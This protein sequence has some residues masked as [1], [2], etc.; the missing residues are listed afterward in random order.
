M[1]QLTLNGQ[2]FDI[3]A[4]R[5]DIQPFL[6]ALENQTTAP[7]TLYVDAA[8][9]DANAGTATAPLLTMQGAFSR[10]PKRV[11]H[12]VNINVGPGTFAGAW[13]EGYTIDRSISQ[14]TAAG[15]QVNGTL[16]NAVAATGASSGTVA[17][18]TVAVFT[19]GATNTITKTAA[20][21]TVNDFRGK[22]L[23]FTSGARSG[24]YYPIMS[25]T[26]TVLTVGGSF[27]ADGGAP[28]NGDSFQIKDYAT[29]FDSSGFDHV[30]SATGY[31]DRYTGVYVW[32]VNNVGAGAEALVFKDVNFRT[33]AAYIDLYIGNSW[34]TLWRCK[35]SAVLNAVTVGG[36]S[37]IAS[38][39]STYV[40]DDSQQGFFA[41]NETLY[42]QQVA[43]QSSIMSV[44]DIA[45]SVGTK[46]GDW[47]FGSGY[48]LQVL[49]A[50]AKNIH[51]AF[52]VSVANI[53]MG[54]G[55]F[56]TLETGVS[57]SYGIGNASLSQVVIDAGYFASCAAAAISANGQTY[58][59]LI[60][61]QGG[62]SN[63]VGVS[64]LN[65]AWAQ[66]ASTSNIGGTDELSVDGTKFSLATLRAATP[67][68]ELDART[69]ARIYQ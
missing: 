48:N 50:Y 46:L 10:I 11:R 1:S 49:Y 41:A 7:V 38:V 37:F 53:Y 29:I 35:F 25:N 23:T 27:T 9:N 64:V 44:G 32:Y 22:L 15:I 54:S 67:K 36:G 5:D 69:G 45:Y 8:G 21:W 28:G 13:V 6:L 16:A 56:D 66:I 17:S 40:L 3:P 47:F 2:T 65:G 59:Q 26:A 20:G 31:W 58:V 18:S 39:G 55:I 68:V 52:W 33:T 4:S 12:P 62:V 43:A 57:V 61:T 34:V 24:K 51:R 63:G 30:P 60:G 19:T 14:E 42:N